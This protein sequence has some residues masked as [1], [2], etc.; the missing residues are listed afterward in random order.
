MRKKDL[1]LQRAKKYDLCPSL[2]AQNPR[3]KFAIIT[4]SPKPKCLDPTQQ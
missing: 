4:P 3:K 1:T 2:S